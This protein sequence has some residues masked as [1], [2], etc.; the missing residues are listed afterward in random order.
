MIN[1]SIAYKIAIA[2][3]RKFLTKVDITLSDGTKLPTFDNGV[4]MSNGLQIDDSTSSD[5]KFEI[6]SAIVNKLTLRI[7]NVNDFYSQ[8]DFNGAQITPYVGL[9][10]ESSV[11]WLKKGVFIVD[12]PTTSGAIITIT[13]YDKM[14]NFDRIYDS[15]LTYPASLLEIVIDACTRCDVIAGF[16]HFDNDTYIVQE[17][18]DDPSITY[19]AIISYAAQIAGC[20]ARCDNDGALQIKWY[21]FSAF[22]DSNGLNGD[23]FDN[24]SPD[25]YM[26]G[27]TA[28]GG[29]F[30]DYSSGGVFDGGNFGALSRWHH[31]HRLVSQSINTDDIIITGIR[32]TAETDDPQKAEVYTAGGEG[33]MLEITGNPM[34]Q[35]GRAET[36]AKFLYGKI[37]GNRFRPLMVS[38][39]SDPSIEAGD[40]AVITDRKGNSFQTVLTRVKLSINGTET[41]ACEAETPGSRN[42]SRMNAETNA[43]IK[44]RREA[45]KQISLYDQIVRQLTQTISQGFGMYT[46]EVVQSDGSAITYMHDKP[47]IKESS[48]VCT[49]TAAGFMGSVDGGTTWA[50][51]ANGNALVKILTAVGINF[52]WARGGT[53]TCGGKN[54]QNGVIKILDDLG[55]QTGIWDSSGLSCKYGSIKVE[56]KYG[57]ATFNEYGGMELALNDAKDSPFRIISSSYTDTPSGQQYLAPGVSCFFRQ[58]MGGYYKVIGY[59]LHPYRSTISNLDIAAGLNTDGYAL[60]CND[61]AWIYKDIELSGSSRIIWR[62]NKGDSEWVSI[63]AQSHEVVVEGN[64]SCTGTKNRIVKTLS[65]GTRA[66]NAYETPEAYFADFGNGKIGA[67]GETDILFEKIFSETIS[68]NVPYYVSLTKCGPGDLWVSC[69]RADGFRVTG[70][71]G[72]IFDWSVTAHQKGY[73]S[74]RLKEVIGNGNSGSTRE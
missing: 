58:N 56:G 65:Y 16:A 22:E 39:L 46:T 52:D 8:Y 21:D 29:N 66:L 11:E 57:V 68:A 1:T 15:P 17:R 55:A 61:K 24:Y 42:T 26:S 5:G 2:R 40:P 9:Q 14:R 60:V 3:E 74:E 49:K 51:D 62:Y 41:Y 48:Y 18:P 54:N 35:K 13:A 73:E 23:K 59:S 34:I 43:L 27:D 19:R 30:T 20:F 7:D 25:K 45:E 71:P 72:L 33:Y 64:L 47:T 67:G 4:I 50:I 69:K 53:L 12:E 70:T 31:I 44:A 38:A 63:R 10:L 6:G 28:D 32:V 36:V 37:G